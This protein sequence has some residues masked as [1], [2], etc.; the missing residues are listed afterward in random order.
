MFCIFA[1]A[2]AGIPVFR[3]RHPGFPSPASRLDKVGPEYRAGDAD[4]SAT[5][6]RVSLLMHLAKEPCF[7]ELRTQQQLGYMVFSGPLSHGDGH[8]VGSAVGSG[9][10]ALL[11]VFFLKKK[12]V[13]L[14]FFCLLVPWCPFRAPLSS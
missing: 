12:K 2:A 4:V 11:F 10:G 1:V 6:A 13:F 9:I 5:A 7:D 14:L 3:R 8:V